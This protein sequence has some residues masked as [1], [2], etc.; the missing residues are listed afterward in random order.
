V[1]FGTHVGL[2]PDLIRAG[3]CR[4]VIDVPATA[5]G[6]RG[7]AAD[8]GAQ[9]SRS[10]CASDVEIEARFKAEPTQPPDADLG[11]LWTGTHQDVGAV[12]RRKDQGPIPVGCPSMLNRFLSCQ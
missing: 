2:V 3:V 12:A 8:S 7:V 4:E 1:M 9:S 10:P 6:T 5:A 11:L